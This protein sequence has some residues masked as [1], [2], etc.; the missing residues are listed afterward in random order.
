MMM[1][2]WEMMKVMAVTKHIISPNWQQVNCQSE[3]RMFMMMMTKKMAIMMAL[4]KMMMMSGSPKWQ[5]L[6]F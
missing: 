6:H 4:V 5:R 2:M 1:K 3:K